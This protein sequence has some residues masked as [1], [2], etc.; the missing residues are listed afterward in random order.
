MSTGGGSSWAD[1]ED[2]NRSTQSLSCPWG[3]PGWLGCMRGRFSTC[4][5]TMDAA[6]CSTW[7]ASRSLGFPTV[8][9]N[10][11]SGCSGGEE[12]VLRYEKYSVLCY[13]AIIRNNE[14]NTCGCPMLLP[15]K[16]SEGICGAPKGKAEGLLVPQW[17][18]KV[19]LSCH[20]SQDLWGQLDVPPHVAAT[21]AWT[22]WNHL[23]LFWSLP[24]LFIAKRGQYHTRHYNK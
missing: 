5:A 2:G 9:G 14:I 4:S 6:L 10:T 20:L 22:K 15:T 21:P 1:N 7:R 23:S 11:A 8:G 18:F 12:W 16:L 19:S 3:M 17:P 24:F 13:K